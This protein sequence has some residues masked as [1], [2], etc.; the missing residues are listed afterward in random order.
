M[1]ERQ[2]CSSLPGLNN[3]RKSNKKKEQIKFVSFLDILLICLF[4]LYLSLVIEAFTR[5]SRNL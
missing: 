1:K 4:Q 3:S 2:A 5:L